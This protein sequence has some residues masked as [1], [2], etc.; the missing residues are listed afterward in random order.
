MQTVV[1]PLNLP[2]PLPQ[3][4]P[5]DRLDLTNWSDLQMQQL[6]ESNYQNNK[7]VTRICGCFINMLQHGMERTQQSLMR[8]N[9]LHIFG[10]T[11]HSQS[12]LT[13]VFVRVFSVHLR[14]FN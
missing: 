7:L 11:I 3:R 14:V 13:E 1:G 12:T 6:L 2:L 8:L 10:I 4:S 5:I 9:A